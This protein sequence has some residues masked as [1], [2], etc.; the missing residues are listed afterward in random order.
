MQSALLLLA[1]CNVR[2]PTS[3]SRRTFASGLRPLARPLMGDVRRELSFVCRS[4][5][6]FV[7]SQQK[8]CREPIAARSARGAQGSHMGSFVE[9]CVPLRFSERSG[10]SR[11]RGCCQGLGCPLTGRA[12]LGTTVPC[13]HLVRPSWRSGDIAL[14]WPLWNHGARSSQRS[15]V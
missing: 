13:W 7:P 15:F 10:G 12:R 4:V 1:R 6:T 11:S 5:L 2:C 9:R 14:H 8:V 3:P